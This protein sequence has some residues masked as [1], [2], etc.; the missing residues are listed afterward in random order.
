[1]KLSTSQHSRFLKTLDDFI[2]WDEGVAYVEPYYANGRRGRPPWGIEKML[3][4]YLLQC[5][6]ALSDEGIEEAIDDSDALRSFMG[7][8][9]IHEPIPDATTWLKFRLFSPTMCWFGST[10][11]RSG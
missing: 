9:F 6:F 3:R 1:M 8:D 11:N 4:M 2:P 10:L 5:G 7:I